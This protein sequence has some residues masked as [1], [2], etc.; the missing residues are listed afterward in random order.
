[1]DVLMARLFHHGRSLAYLS[2]VE[3][4]VFGKQVVEYSQGGL[5]IQ[6]DNVLG[7]RLGL[8]QTTI[9]HQL[10]C[11]TYVGDFLVKRLK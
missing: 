11:E 7:P 5:E 8:R 2:L 4:F 1:M 9:H 3:V 10:E 6:V